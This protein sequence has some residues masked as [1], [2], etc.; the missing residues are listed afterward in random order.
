MCEPS[1]ARPTDESTRALVLA[2]ALCQTLIES[3]HD[4]GGEVVGA[5]S[6]GAL[7][8][9]RSALEAEVASRAGRGR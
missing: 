7:T 1:S 3:L 9:L 6:F 4:V 5:A 2:T 8:E